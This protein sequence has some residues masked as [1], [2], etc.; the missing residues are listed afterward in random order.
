VTE[1]EK[2]DAEKNDLLLYS[3]AKE[4][5]KENVLTT[6]EYVEAKKDYYN[7]QF[8]TC[9]HCLKTFSNY[10]LRKRHELTQH[11]EKDLNFLCDQCEKKYT[12]KHSLNYHIQTRHNENQSKIIC[13]ICSRKFPSELSLKIHKAKHIS[14]EFFYVTSV[15]QCLHFKLI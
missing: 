14:S 13:D 4:V 1:T 10:N 6:E 5:L 9:A 7:Y 15:M 12:N 11:F 3:D 8:R 2:T